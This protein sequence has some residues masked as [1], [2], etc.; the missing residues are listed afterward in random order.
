MHTPPPQRTH[1]ESA[2]T[3]GVLIAGKHYPR[4]KPHIYLKPH[5]TLLRLVRPDLDAVQVEHLVTRVTSPNFIAAAH[6][7]ETHDTLVRVIA[8]MFANGERQLAYI[9]VAASVTRLGVGQWL[10]DRGP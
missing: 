6:R 3:R 2:K 5:R 4:K 1:C 8:Q 10:T 9:R 7:V